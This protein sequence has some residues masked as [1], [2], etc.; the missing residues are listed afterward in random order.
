M[1]DGEDR[2]DGKSSPS[3]VAVLGVIGSETCHSSSPELSG[4][5][6]VTDPT[7]DEL[8]YIPD[9]MTPSTATPLGFF[10]SGLSTPSGMASHAGMLLVTDNSGDELWHVSDPMTPSTATRLGDDFPSNLSSPSGMTSHDG[11]LLVTDNSGNELWH[12]PDPMTP[13]TAAFLGYF[14]SGIGAPLGM[15]SVIE[16]PA[17]LEG[18]TI[19]AN[20]VDKLYLGSGEVV[21]A[22]LGSEKVYG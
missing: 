1:P 18:F 8:S 20:V 16:A 6:L 11:M 9:P 3:R 10:P 17:S 14:P 2:L 22:Y 5:L 21:A 15:T 7:R 19:G 12:V 4:M 13:G